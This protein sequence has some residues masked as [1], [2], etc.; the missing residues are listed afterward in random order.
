M[1]AM[2]AIPPIAMNSSAE[3]TRPV[4]ATASNPARANTPAWIAT[5]RI[6]GARSADGTGGNLGR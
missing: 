5:N 3:G 6:A 4:G 2:T 1:T